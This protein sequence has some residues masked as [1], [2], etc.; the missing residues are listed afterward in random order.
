MTPV[1]ALAGGWATS[2][3][4][5]GATS[6]CLRRGTTRTAQ[7]SA[8]STPRSSRSGASGTCS[9]TSAALTT[10]P[11]RAPGPCRGV[12][13]RTS[14]PPAAAVPPAAS[15]LA[16]PRVMPPLPKQLNKAWSFKALPLG[17]SFPGVQR[18]PPQTC[19]GQGGGSHLHTPSAPGAACIPPASWPSAHPQPA[20][21]EQPIGRSWGLS[22]RDRSWSPQGVQ[23]DCGGWGAQLCPGVY[24]QGPAAP[25]LCILLCPAK[26]SPKH[27]G[28]RM[29]AAA[30]G[31]GPLSQDTPKRIITLIIRHCKLSL[32]LFRSLF[33]F[34]SESLMLKN[35][36]ITRIVH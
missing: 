35:T 3:L 24:S 9:G 29:G 12:G 11:T 28:A 19:P 32:A 6:T 7:T 26:V 21:T 36:L 27:W 13:S 33:H 5:T 30:L 34:N 25:L 18:G 8:L 1:L 15:P 4:A 17:P 16:S 23:P 10:P 22:S 14:F 20:L 31:V 2:T